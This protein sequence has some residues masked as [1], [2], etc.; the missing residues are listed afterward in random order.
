MVATSL[1]T[2][3]VICKHCSIAM[4]SKP[5]LTDPVLRCIEVYLNTTVKKLK[6]SFTFGKK[7]HFD[8]RSIVC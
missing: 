1:Q 5:V 6:D 4:L 7:R 2:I 3:Y 8:G